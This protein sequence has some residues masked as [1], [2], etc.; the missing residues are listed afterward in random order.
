MPA[1]SMWMLSLV[2]SFYLTLHY[3]IGRQ[4]RREMRTLLCKRRFLG[5]D[6]ESKKITTGTS[7]QRKQAACN[8]SANGNIRVSKWEHRRAR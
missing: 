3:L 7:T 2:Q 5:G 8:M 6:K 1:A 4:F